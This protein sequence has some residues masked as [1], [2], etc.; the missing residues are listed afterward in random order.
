VPHLDD[1]GAE[2]GEITKKLGQRPRM[3]RQAAA[4]REV[5]AGRG[6]AVPAQLGQ[7]RFDVAAEHHD[8][9]RGAKSRG[10]SSRAA[11]AAPAGSTTCLVRSRQSTSPRDRLPSETVTTRS[12][13]PDRMLKG[14]SPGR[15]TA[16]PSAMVAQAWTDTGCPAASQAGYGATASAYTPT[17]VISGSRTALK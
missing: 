6:Q 1:I 7:Q 5:A 11:P 12:A 9:R 3:I 16:M 13:G 14:M 15:L 2:I 8:H 17:T 10:F 4:E